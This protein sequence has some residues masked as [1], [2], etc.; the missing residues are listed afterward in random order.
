MIFHACFR[1][2]YIKSHVSY[3][4][5]CRFCPVVSADRS[6]KVKH[7]NEHHFDTMRDICGE[8]GARFETDVCLSKHVRLTH[9]RNRVMCPKDG[10][11]QFFPRGEGAKLRRHL[12]KFHDPESE[13][14]R[15]SYK[16]Q[17]PECNKRIKSKH[18]LRAHMSVKHNAGGNMAKCEFCDYAVPMKRRNDIFR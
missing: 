17:C 10:C 5:L 7:L 1:L 2:N 9:A 18:L 3:A 14:L 4:H 11:K 13:K 6:D 8:C 12:R 16:F 15:A